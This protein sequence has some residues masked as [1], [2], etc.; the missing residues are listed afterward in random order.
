MIRNIPPVTKNLLFINLIAFLAM[1]ILGGIG[2]DLNDL[3][4]LHFFMASNFHIYQV[5][6]YM[7]MHATWAHILL[8]MF[9]LW[10]FG[11]TI[12]RTWGSRRFLIY[13]IVCGLGAGIIQ[14]L[15]QFV[16]FWVVA[17]EQ[18]PGFELKDAALVAANSSAVLNKWTTVGAS[19]AIYGILLAFGMTYPN[20]Q[21]FIFPIPFPIKGKW[22][23]VICAAIELL[24]ATG[25][26]SDGVAHV[27][28]LGGMLFGLGL[29][30]YWRKHPYMGTQSFAA[31]GV[32]DS[33]RQKW[34][35]SKARNA[36]HTSHKESDWDYNARKKA[37][38]DEIDR[39]L[40]KIRKSGYDSLTKEEKQ[41]LFD[42]GK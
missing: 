19:G 6:T 13:Y 12:E 30:L 35:Q 39:I 17:A 28:H 15:A 7:F 22:F 40:D 42:L 3:L 8:N 38:Q 2:V 26:N 20:E 34:A 29:I 4:G 41:E 27:A 36:Q 9:A 5:V 18:I 10:M 32:F 1:L 23:V 31:R 25:T 11:S 16:D 14:E 33:L 21:I 37:N 24:A